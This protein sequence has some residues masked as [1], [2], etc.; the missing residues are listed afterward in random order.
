MNQAE[1]DQVHAQLRRQL[2]KTSRHVCQ[3]IDPLNVILN[4]LKSR[5][6]PQFL[7]IL[8][9]C[10]QYCSLVDLVAL[11]QTCTGW[12]VT[13]RNQGLFENH[14]LEQGL[15]P[16]VR[17]RFWLHS[18]FSPASPALATQM[19]PTFINP[20]NTLSS[21]Q[22]KEVFDRVLVSV[23]SNEEHAAMVKIYASDIQRVIRRLNTENP[24]LEASKSLMKQQ[25]SLLRVIQ[26]VNETIPYH[27]SMNFI[28]GAILSQNLWH[29]AQAYWIF[30]GSC[31]SP[32][33]QLQGLYQIQV[34]DTSLLNLRLFQVRTRK[35]LTLRTYLSPIEISLV[36][37]VAHEINEAEYARIVRSF[38][39][40]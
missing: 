15:E 7:N 20:N 11:A 19:V 39:H 27:R 18:T 35:H 10:A 23:N 5:V 21:L 26:V 30:M 22:Q 38:S 6:T 29:E 31:V 1:L 40:V 13:C 37:Y 33:Y 4:N 16:S 32:S 24:A 34:S 8:K 3:V 12:I 36:F 9:H 28:I 25:Q 17:N 2:D 14:V